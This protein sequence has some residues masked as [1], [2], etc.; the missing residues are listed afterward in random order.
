[1]ITVAARKGKCQPPVLVDLQCPG[2]GAITLKLMQ[3][4]MW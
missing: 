2:T 3:T 1:M 4:E